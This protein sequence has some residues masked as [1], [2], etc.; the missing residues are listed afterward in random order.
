M[1]TTSMTTTPCSWC[2]TPMDGDHLG[3]RRH[4]GCGDP[5]R[6]LSAAVTADHLGPCSICGTTTVRYG[7]HATS[8]LCPTCQSSSEGATQ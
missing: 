2:G 8:T 7:D 3:D 6:S 4:P 1:T 5:L